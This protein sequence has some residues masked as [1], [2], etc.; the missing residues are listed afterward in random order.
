MIFR[1]AFF[2]YHVAMKRLP[3]IIILS[4]LTWLIP[5]G[6]AAQSKAMLLPVGSPFVERLLALS[7]AEGRVARHSS[8]PITTGDALIWAQSFAGTSAL[9]DAL[10][11]ELQAQVKGSSLGKTI[12][13]PQDRLWL[14]FQPVFTLELHDHL[15]QEYFGW[16][17]PAKDRHALLELPLE[18]GLSFKEI[19]LEL[20][21][22]SD[23]ALNEHLNS[24]YEAQ[25]VPNFSN[26]PEQASNIDFQFPRRTDVVLAGDGVSLML[27]RDSLFFGTTHDG[28]LTLGDAPDWYDAIRVQVHDSMLSYTWLWIS[29]EP[30][31]TAAEK[32]LPAYSLLRS[33]QK[34]LFLHRL[35]VRPADFL[36]F[37]IVEGSMVGGIDPSLKHM[38]P[39]SVFH[40]MFAWED[41]DGFMAASSL[42]GV[43]LN[44]LPV[45]GIQ[46]YGSFVMNQLQT[47]Y[48]LENYAG[49][50]SSIPNA[51]AFMV[52]LSGAKIV[53]NGLLHGGLEWFETNPWMYIRENALNSFFA[54]KRLNNGTPGTKR[55]YDQP[56]G[57]KHGPDSRV[58][59]GWIGFI[60]GDDLNLEFNASYRLAGQNRI[61]TPYRTG[62]AAIKAQTPSG[63]AEQYVT[64]GVQGDVKLFDSAVLW[65]AASIRLGGSIDAVWAKTWGVA[66]DPV[67]FDLQYGLWLSLGM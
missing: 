14:R 45:K 59:S 5:V 50:T 47:A 64:L 13:D 15:N 32:A 31:L 36:S 46:L 25:A 4:V 16:V 63:T 43:E 2:R 8:F 44:I 17:R 34:N 33:Q 42:L 38:H 58:F 53:G 57:Y 61:D 1:T 67:L 39:L 20:W 27:L 35:D 55:L 51:F 40:N 24:M 37:A 48:E 12:P 29:L 30:Y 10:I 3:A 9:A 66:A 28:S 6:L 56:I 62:E 49:D 23:F 21:G 26:V 54:R 18:I 7:L 41:V 11:L 60:Q 19:G 52:G 22:L 65:R